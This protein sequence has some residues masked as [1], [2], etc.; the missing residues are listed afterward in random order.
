MN[1]ITVQTLLQTTD[2]SI[3]VEDH[4][5]NTLSLRELFREVSVCFGS[6]QD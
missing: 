6:S 5:P 4:C 2:A 1:S 3:Q